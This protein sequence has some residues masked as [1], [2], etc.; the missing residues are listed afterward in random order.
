MCSTKKYSIMKRKVLLLISILTLT[1]YSCD[2]SDKDSLGVSQSSFNNVSSDG[3]TLEV[4][5]TSASEWT[6]SKNAKWCS[7]TPQKG[8]GNQKLT[9]EIEANLNETT[10]SATITVTPSTGGISQAIKITQDGITTSFNPETY[11]YKLPVIFH[12]LYHDKNNDEQYVKVGR[13]PEILERVNELYRNA[14]TNSA[15]MNL[16]FVLA[17]ED[18]N[19]KTLSEPGVERIEWKTAAIDINDFMF[20]NNGTYNYLIWEPNDYINIMVYQ[21]TDNDVMGVSHFPYSPTAN[22]LPG[23]E[24]DSRYLTGSNLK[25]AYCVSINNSYIYE[26]TT[27]AIP[28][29]NDMAIT[30]AH[31]LGHYLGLYHVFSEATENGVDVCE[32]TDYCTDTYTYNRKAYEAWLGT[33]SGQSGSI[34][35][36]ELAQRH[37]CVQNIDFTSRNI[38]DYAYSYLNEFTA[39]QKSRIRHILTYSPL[40]PGPKKGFASTRAIHDG[41]LDLPIRVM[42]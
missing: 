33:L 28:N 13:L 38:M 4:N 22:P 14:G 41:P 12:V 8:S 6:V 9:L 21:F 30:L 15:N 11:H 42:K 17:T 20:S 25:Y 10:R 16:E 36:N 37:D 24:T 40:I 1:F 27:T 31:E 34:Y 2:D 7:V 19:G 29:Q 35:F 32:D 3:A 39:Q 5:I 23:T 18:P 26:K